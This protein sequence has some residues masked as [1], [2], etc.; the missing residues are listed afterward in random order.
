MDTTLQTLIPPVGYQPDHHQ[1]EKTRF[2]GEG[3]ANLD[4]IERQNKALAFLAPLCLALRERYPSLGVSLERA[5]SGDNDTQL[6]VRCKHRMI[7]CGFRVLTNQ[8]P[9][10]ATWVLY[11]RFGKGGSAH[12]TPQDALDYVKQQVTNHRDWFRQTYP[13]LAALDPK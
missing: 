5:T 4:T 10:P 1:P 9:D 7:T 11:D 3:F 2:L 13:R 8:N 6:F 12:Y